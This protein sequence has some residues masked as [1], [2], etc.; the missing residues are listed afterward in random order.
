MQTKDTTILEINFQRNGMNN[1]KLQSLSVSLSEVYVKLSG[2]S[3][4][5]AGKPFFL[6]AFL[7]VNEIYNFRYNILSKHKENL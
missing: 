1:E 3:F 7:L 4:L 6:I 5:T 2:K